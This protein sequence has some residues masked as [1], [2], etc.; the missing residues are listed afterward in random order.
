MTPFAHLQW[1]LGACYVR[2]R[3]TSAK[4]R[5]RG[6]VAEILDVRLAGYDPVNEAT[7]SLDLRYLSCSTRGRL[8]ET[9]CLEW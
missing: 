6:I 4:F 8:H 2:V 7:F 3:C 9:Y 5:G 1:Q